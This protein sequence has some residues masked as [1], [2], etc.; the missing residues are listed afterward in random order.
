MLCK[1]ISRHRCIGIHNQLSFI[2][3]QLP[4]PE[5][6]QSRDGNPGTQS[7]KAF[8][9]NGRRCRRRIGNGIEHQLTE[10]LLYDSAEIQTYETEYINKRRASKNLPPYQPLY[11]SADVD[12][13]LKLFET[14]PFDEWFEALPGVRIHF[15]HTGH[16]IGSAAMSLEVVEAESAELEVLH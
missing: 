3:G 11:T 5:F 8:H 4:V 16:L 14:F 13:T 1:V 9:K 7:A 15:T 10:I 6:V 12:K 2:D